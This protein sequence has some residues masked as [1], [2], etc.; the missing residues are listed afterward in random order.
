ML[1]YF[2]IAQPLVGIIII[3]NMIKYTRYDVEKIKVVG[4][5]ISII[6]LIISL[7]MFILFDFSNIYYQF[8]KDI[9]EIKIINLYLGLDGISIYFVLLTTFIT[10]IVI[11]SNWYSIK[12][13]IES[14]LIII[15]LLF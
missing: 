11:L 15:L 7:I 5:I 6:N 12:K 4:L 14:Y 8:V 3:I 2:L 10:P 1:S 13:N 9:S